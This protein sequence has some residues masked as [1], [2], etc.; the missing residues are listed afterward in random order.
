MWLCLAAREAGKPGNKTVRLWWT[1]ASHITWVWAH[2]PPYFIPLGSNHVGHIYILHYYNLVSALL[3]N[4]AVHVFT[5]REKKHKRDD[6]DISLGKEMIQ[7]SLGKE[8][9]QISRWEKRWYR[10]LAGK[11]DTQQRMNW[12]LNSLRKNRIISGLSSAY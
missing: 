2:Y 10:Y 8:M 7:I 5:K 12:L 9:I 11:R 1:W 4:K 6:T 3:D